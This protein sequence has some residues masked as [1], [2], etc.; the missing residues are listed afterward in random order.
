MLT[1]DILAVLRKD[2]VR[3]ANILGFAHY[4]TVTDL[5]V[6]GDSVML[7]GVSD[8]PWVYIS[9]RSMAE[10]RELLSRLSSEDTCFA[11]IEDWMMPEIVGQTPLKWCLSTQKLVLP[12]EHQFAVT[13]GV[14]LVKSINIGDAEYLFQNYDYQEY[15]SVAYIEERLR[16]G[17]SA[18]IYYEGNPV[19]WALTHDDG[20][21]GLLKVLEPFRG[22]GYAL[23]VTGFLVERIREQ[24][25][26]P[27]VHI[28]EDNVQS[29]GLSQKMGFVKQGLTHWFELSP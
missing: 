27:F 17:P 13:D 7:K 15:T 8:R 3:N 2:P 29:L 10:L 1:A 24:G 4:N 26:V 22:R 25:A 19:A 14:S 20:A 23:A 5:R 6:V 16:K 18:A 9:S 28:E 21:I 12:A 11:V